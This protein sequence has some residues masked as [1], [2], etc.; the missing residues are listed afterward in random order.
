MHFSFKHLQVSSSSEYVD[1]EFHPILPSST[2]VP[3]SITPA[4]DSDSDSQ[5]HGH[6]SV[7]SNPPIP[8]ALTSLV[9]AAPNPL[10]IVAQKPQVPAALQS[11]APVPR[12]RTRLQDGI[13]MPK[14]HMLSNIL[15]PVPY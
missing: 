9:P 7:A 15:F 11:P 10:V 2:P 6:L 12:M 5:P 4:V 13:Q 14:L 3:I 1:I 8:A